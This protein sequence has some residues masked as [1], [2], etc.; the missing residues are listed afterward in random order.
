MVVDVATCTHTC[1]G[2]ATCTYRSVYT[3]EKM[4]MYMYTCMYT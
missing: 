1:Q 2:I 4:N 3:Y